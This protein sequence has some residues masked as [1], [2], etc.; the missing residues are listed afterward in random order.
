M[1]KSA[2]QEIPSG[3][4]GA[5]KGSKDNKD[6][7]DNKTSEP[8]ISAQ[9]SPNGNDNSKRESSGKPRENKER[10]KT[11]TSIVADKAM[12]NEGAAISDKGSVVSSGGGRT[13]QKQNAE[14]KPEKS[15]AKSDIATTKINPHTAE[16][17][18]EAA[19]EEKAYSA[20]GVEP[21][22][23][24]AADSSQTSAERK[25]KREIVWDIKTYFE[26]LGT[27]VLKSLKLPRD[28]K[29]VSQRDVRIYGL[30]DEKITED[31][32]VFCF[33]AS[34]ER[35]LMLYTSKKDSSKAFESGEYKTK[36]INGTK[37]YY[38]DGEGV[39]G[40]YMYSGKVGFVFYACGMTEAELETA[41]ASLK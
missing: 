15:K 4:V 25:N 3:Y 16:A 32:A 2:V 35:M 41:L 28:M 11:E 5:S 12:S 24:S 26:Y 30:S 22:L 10:K 40:G 9:P 6:N 36:T 19:S 29:N 8:E 7:K 31:E 39:C 23:F 27:D 1:N 21:A 33:K 13:S 18:T 37:V 17:K 34:E 14:N 20:S 38:N